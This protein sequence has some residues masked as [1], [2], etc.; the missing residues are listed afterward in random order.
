MDYF[1]L[2][3]ISPAFTLDPKTLE[4][5]YFREQ[6]LHHPDRFA[7]KPPEERQRALL[8]SVE[9]NAAYDTLKNPLSRAQYL[10]H[11]QGIAVGTEAGSVKPS[12]AI[13]V[14]AMELRETPPE[15]NTL[16]KMIAD[17]IHTI[18]GYYASGAFDHMAQETLRLGY[19]IK[20]QGP[21]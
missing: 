5:A 7:G 10:L 1:Q 21:L 19:L 3:Q 13:L 11:L 4:A 14:E 2:L 12:Q 9:I 18:A 6:R 16:E 15:K 17:S 8:R 20:V